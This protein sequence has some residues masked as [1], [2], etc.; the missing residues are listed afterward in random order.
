M[1]IR[2]MGVPESH[3]KIVTTLC[4]TQVNFILRFY[5]VTCQKKILSSTKLVS[6]FPEKDEVTTNI[7]ICIK[8]NGAHF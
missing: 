7:C 3:K 2:S 4:K 1:S 8:T 6:V 5:F